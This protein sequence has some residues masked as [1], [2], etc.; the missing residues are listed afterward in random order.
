[1]FLLL[2]HDR[3]DLQA[4]QI[5][6]EEKKGTKDD[7]EHNSSSATPSLPIN[8]TTNITNAYTNS[9]DNIALTPPATTKAP[10]TSTPPP[11]APTVAAAPIKNK[12]QHHH[13]QQQSPLICRDND[14]PSIS[15]RTIFLRLCRSTKSMQQH[16]D[17]SCTHLLYPVQPTTYSSKGL[18]HKA[19]TN[20]GLTGLIG[21]G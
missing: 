16:D 4:D 8:S 14:V 18:P 3:V 15:S 17:H 21:L 20:H 10:P 11:T 5:R 6:E 1:M 13:Q 2:Y 12:N 7:D 19:N 9:T